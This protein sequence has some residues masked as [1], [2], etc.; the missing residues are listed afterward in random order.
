[1]ALVAMADVTDA[2]DVIDV[3]DAG[4][5][6]AS[7]CDG[8]ALYSST[9]VPA[10]GGGVV[11]VDF[12]SPV[13]LAVVVRGNDDDD[14]NYHKDTAARVSDM[15]ATAM[16]TAATAVP[17]T[18]TTLVRDTVDV[19][20][21]TP[22][23]VLSVASTELLTAGTAVKRRPDTR[24]LD[25]ERAP[26]GQR[27]GEVTT[28]DREWNVDLGKLSELK[29]C[30]LPFSLPVETF[31]TVQVDVEADVEVEDACVARGITTS[32]DIM[33]GGSACCTRLSF[34]ETC[35]DDL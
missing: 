13:Q 33:I 29:L 7:Q 24:A 8:K 21:D 2:T 32:P 3:T 19:L 25:L 5:L 9:P 15:A 6:L 1:M 20:C 27:V 30:E 35:D 16:A 10:R 22:V 12:A 34:S 28:V 18:T 26:T 4:M 14:K 31:P 17:T 11:G 23:S